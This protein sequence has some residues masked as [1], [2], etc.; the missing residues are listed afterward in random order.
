VPF[1]EVHLTDV[2]AREEMRRRLLF[3]DLAVEVITG[4]GPEGYRK[5]LQ[6]LW[7]RRGER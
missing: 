3:A 5:A 1:V 7:R 6:V 2:A 4:Q